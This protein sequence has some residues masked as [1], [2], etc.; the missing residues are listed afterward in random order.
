MGA[1]G[2]PVNLELRGRRVVVIGGVPAR[3]GKVDGLLA[4]G[5][6]DV[7]VVGEDLPDELDGGA[8]GGVRVERRRWRPEDLDGALLVIAHDPDPRERLAIALAARDRGALVN[9]VDDI[10][11]CDVA[12]PAVVRRGDLLVAIGTGGASPAVASILRRRLETEYGPEWGELLRVVR[13]VREE[14]LAD[15]P[16]L[17]VRGERW[18]A[19]LDPDEAAGLVRMG[20]SEELHELLRARLLEEAAP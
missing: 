10:P 9:M 13:E 3:E 14:T 12:M 19:A 1:F 18:R 4:G 11:N 17:R 6:D 20:R 15:L 7:L 16:D 5:A 8:D 2:Y